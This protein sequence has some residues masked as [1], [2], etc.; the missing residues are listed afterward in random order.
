VK[1][2]LSIS[3]WLTLT[4]PLIAVA[5]EGFERTFGGPEQELGYS[6]E[7]TADN[8]FVIVG[9]TESFGAGSSDIFLVRTD[10]EGNE[11]WSRTYGGSESEIGYSVQQ[12]PDYGFI[13][14]G[15]TYSFGEGNGDV[16]LVRTDLAGDTLWTRTYGGSGFDWGYSV[17]QTQ[18]GGFII[19]GS[20]T[21][22]GS[23]SG[24][25]YAIR[26][27]P[28]GVTVWERSYGGQQTE[29]ARSVQHTTDGGFIFAGTTYTFGTATGDLYIIKTDSSGT[30]VWTRTF[31]QEGVD[32]GN[33]VMETQ[34]GGYVVAG[35]LYSTQTMSRD[36][37]LVR[38]DATGDSLWTKTYGGFDRDVGWS[39][40]QVA[41]AG[42]IIA[43]FTESFGAGDQEVYMIR[44]NFLGNTL[45]TR[46]YGGSERDSGKSVWVTEDGGYVV[47]GDTESYGQGNRDLYMIKTNAD[48]HVGIEPGE[49]VA[50]SIPRSFVLGQNFPNPFNPSTTIA[51]TIPGFVGT[52]E[53]GG[54]DPGR[55]ANLT[56]FDLRG[57]RIITLVD[58][59]LGPGD[60]RVTWDGKDDAGR[61]IP[62]GIYL[63]RLRSEGGILTRKMTIAK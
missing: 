38:M 53:L 60:H 11:L 27:D 54:I 35:E 40:R 39:V 9:S 44:T 59:D 5:Q 8:G 51:F 46:T 56:I 3:T 17:D 4:I 62:S 30:P 24:D 20:T 63:Y 42:Y 31:G 41:D 34:D 13:I 12:T 7:Q 45:W 28:F 22:F 43:G 19:A 50:P 61:S 26:T 15:F 49:P 57:R 33:S 14:A 47:G 36:I 32:E 6:V 25:V 23:E 16:Y 21:S 18:D 52:G 29:Y 48:G 37:Y 1:R 2:A 58:S 10:G 55:D